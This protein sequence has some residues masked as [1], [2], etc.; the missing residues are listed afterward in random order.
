MTPAKRTD[1]ATE[2]LRAK[3]IGCAQRL[4]ARDGASALTMRA[5]AAEARCAVGLPYKV[6]ANREELIAELIRVEYARL[7]EA[8][9]ALI[10]SAGTRTVGRNLGHYAELLLDSPVV[11]LA[12]EL[13]HD[14]ALSKA[15]GEEAVEAGLVAAIESTVVQYLAAEKQLGRVA[16][17]VDER[18]FGFVIAGAVHNLLATGPAYPHP[19]LRGVKRRLG[20]IADRLVPLRDTSAAGA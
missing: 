3:L 5:L 17:S 20:A 13:H 9:A 6:F 1:D 11:S 15:V 7:R 16:P 8:F 18:A 4:V 10:A 19:G 12:P 2:R 14:A